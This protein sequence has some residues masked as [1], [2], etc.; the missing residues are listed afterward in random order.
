MKTHN[1]YDPTIA[2][3]I[4]EPDEAL[5]ELFDGGLQYEAAISDALVAAAPS[6]PVDLRRLASESRAAQ[7]KACVAAMTSGAAVIIGGVLPIDQRG[8]RTGG[9]NIL[10]RGQDQPEGQ[11]RYHPVEVKWH[12]IIERGRSM[13]GQVEASLIYSTLDQPSPAEAR[14]LDRHTMR[15]ASREPDLIQLAHYHRLLEAAGFASDEDPRAAIIGT[16]DTLGRPVLSWVDLGQ[17]L[18]RTF[19]RRE[20]E[21]WRLRSLLER[22]DHEHRFR[23]D[24]AIVAQSQTGDPRRDPPPLVHPIVTGE[25]TRCQWWEHCRPQLH[26]DD[27]SLRIDKGP[28]DVREISSLRR[29]GIATV[30]DLAEADVDRLL[31]WYLPEVTHRTGAESRLRVAARRA[32]MLLSAVLIERETEGA[33]EVAAAEVEVDFDIETAA[34]G[35]IYLWGFYVVAG[36]EKYYRQFSTFADLDGEAETRLAREALSWLQDLAAGPRSLTVYHYS[37]YEVAALRALS[38][39]ERDPVLDWA[40]EYATDQFVDLLEIVKAH[41]FAV[42]GL[43]LKVIAQQAGFSWRDDDPGG[44]NS[45]RWFAEAVHG[46]TAAVRAQARQRVLEYN[47]DDV[48]ATAQVRRWLRA[49]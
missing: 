8:H 49:Q 5:A 9:P 24:V 28:L 18:V 17:P 45:Q 31:E 7:V 41:F 36:D 20:P 19:S 4:W 15:I 46:E 13:R 39:R 11:P 30:T 33:I 25:C 21:G 23:V 42:G 47:E 38:D 48:M 43:G 3:V 2:S 22:Y 34:N 1:A 29:H 32:R 40:V 44:L 27:V 6:P 35:R 37:A 10:I 26:P 12:K 14:E 16:D